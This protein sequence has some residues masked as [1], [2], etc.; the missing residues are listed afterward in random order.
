M[1]CPHCH[2][3]VAATA[4]FC[5]NCG[6]R[7]DG[8]PPVPTPSLQPALAAAPAAA[9]IG[10]APETRASSAA[11]ALLARIK[12]IILTPRSEWQVIEP[13]RT[14][15]A[16]LYAGYL[17]PL[18]A[19]A[20]VLG[21]IHVSVIGISL[22]FGAGVLRS[23]ITVGLTSALMTLVMGLI[24]MFVVGMIINGLAPTF[25]G[26]RDQ[27]QALK[28]AAYSF[29]PGWLSAL[30]AL[31]PVLPTLLQLV[32]AC[33]GIYV[34]YLGLPVLMRSARERA[35]GY[36]V[37]VVLCCILFGVLL[38][39]LAGLFGHFGARA[40]L[41]GLVPAETEQQQ[42]ERGA[43]AAGNIIGGMLGTDEKGKAGLGAALSNL[44]KAG[45][46]QKPQPAAA[47]STPAAAPADPGSPAAAQNPLGAAGGLLTALGA[48]LGGPNRVEPV[49]FKTL[50]TLLPPS[51]AGLQRTG[52][53]G[54][55][56]QAI[57]VKTTSA[58]ADYAGSGA[59]AHVEI[60]DLSGVSGLMGLANGLVQNDTSQSDTGYEKDVVL[61]G[62]TAHEKYDAQARKGEISMI[63]AKRFTVEVSGEGVPMSALEQAYGDINVSGLEGMKDQGA[64]P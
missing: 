31:S 8:A 63:V 57:G 51:I 11:P 59:T 43:Q 64:Q 32:A 16:Q 14:S 20:A 44:A 17:V 52:V 13:E 27:R 54:E 12:N 1:N 6:Q 26:T 24:S 25:G 50:S 2:K 30:L 39:V 55:G 28:V 35:V 60:A 61:G 58:V 46:A 15:I 9:G 22:P 42:Q 49:D 4:I 21:F 45:A 40:G 34:L 3:P 36:T 38:A 29:T 10:A 41:S 18:A 33:Y 37:S 56:K 19:L 62:R 48:S 5:G 47:G 53:K 7:I 23:P